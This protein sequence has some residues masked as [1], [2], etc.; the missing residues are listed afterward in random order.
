MANF[1]STARSI[2]SPAS[3]AQ[4]DRQAIGQK[5]DEQVC[6]DPPGSFVVDRSH[7]G[8][9]F[10]RAERFLHG[11]QLHVAAPDQLRIVGGEIGAQQIPAFALADVA[12]LVSI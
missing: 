5:R 10:E 9:A 1:S 3:G 7:P 2:K 11:H 6:F 4:R 8:V 12:Q